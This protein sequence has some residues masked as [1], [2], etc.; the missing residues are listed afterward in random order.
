M[1]TY[2]KESLLK[3]FLLFFSVQLVFLSLVIYQHYHKILHEYDMHLGN[4]MMQCHLDSSCHSF[5]SSFIVSKEDKELHTFYTDDEIY[6]LFRKNTQYEKMSIPKDTYLAKRATIQKHALLEYFL[7]LIA[8][9]L[10]SFLFALYAMRPL[11]HALKLNE[12]FVKDIL[13]DFNTPLSALKINLKILK[14]RFGNNDAIKRSDESIQNILSLQDN[15]HYFISQSKLDNED[16]NIHNVLEQRV[17]YFQAMYPNL[18][19]SQECEAT[20]I[21]IVKDVII[22]IIDNLLSNAAKYNKEN[23]TIEI[24]LKNNILSIKDSGIGIKNPQEIFQRYYKE[25][26]QGIGIGLHIVQKLCEELSIGIKVESILGRGTTFTLN[27]TKV[28]LR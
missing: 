14:K 28:M 26:K 21:Y 23:G 3:S 27:L 9:I 20:N 13:H 10:E 7:Y 24:Q 8:L 22:R 4:Q 18:D 19:I 2:E 16:V 15:L 11:K 12:E 1:K 5:T 25:N 17:L 6:M